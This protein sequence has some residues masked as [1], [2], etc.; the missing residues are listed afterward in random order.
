MGLIEGVG[1]ESSKRLP[2]TSLVQEFDIL[3]RNDDKETIVNLLLS[4][5]TSGGDM[6]VIPIVGMGGVGKTTL[7]QI[8]YKDKRVKEHFDLKAWVCVSD[9]FDVFRVTK[10]VLE[11]VTLSTC[12]LK[13]LNL[14][15]VTLQ[16]QLMGKKFLLVLDDVWNENY[17]DWELLSSPF[18]SNTIGSQSL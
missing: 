4:D 12:D 17:A 10:T 7:A 16:E 8:I 14:L 18:K 6:C 15:Q 2:T 5:D 3:G 9:E 1:G 13:D 11:A